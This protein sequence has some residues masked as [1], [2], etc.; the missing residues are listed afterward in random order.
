[1][2]VAAAPAA[3]RLEPITVLI[4]FHHTLDVDKGKIPYRFGAVFQEL[5][6]ANVRIHVCSYVGFKEYVRREEEG[7]RVYYLE[8]EL[9]EFIRRHRLPTV[10]DYEQ[11]S[12]AVLG[13]VICNQKVGKPYWCKYFNLRSTGGKEYRAR[14]LRAGVIFDDNAGICA[15]SAYVGAVPFLI[16]TPGCLHARTNVPAH[17]NFEVAAR[18]F[19]QQIRDPHTRADLINRGRHLREPHEDAQRVFSFGDA[20]DAPSGT[21]FRPVG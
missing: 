4:D 15:A 21:L 18:L 17:N 11:P 2:R 6:A 10:P 19:L 16:R 14:Q 7:S 5:I 1:V 9:A 20:K 8:R 12:G 3:P 13:T